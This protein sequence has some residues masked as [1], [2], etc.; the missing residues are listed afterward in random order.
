MTTE[1]ARTGEF[2]LSEANGARS[3]ENITVAAGHD[4]QPGTVLGIVSASGEYAPFD[5]SASDGTET[6]AGIL[7]SYADSRDGAVKAVAVVRD[8]EVNQHLLIW[9]DDVTDAQRAAAEANLLT[10]GVV[11]R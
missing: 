1:T 8:A 5:P 4:M 9:P 3:R 11:V 2:I 7:H 6:A 10:T